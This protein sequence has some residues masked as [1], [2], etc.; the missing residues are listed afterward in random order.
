VL[1]LRSVESGQTLFLP[2][3]SGGNWPTNFFASVPVN[4][5]A[6]G[7]ALA[8][9]FVNGIPSTASVVN[10]D[11]I[12]VPT[13]ITLTGAKVLPNGSFQLVFTNR[14]GAIFSALSTT[15]LLLPLTQWTVL[16]SVTEGPAGQFQV[17]DPQAVGSPQHFYRVRSP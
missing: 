9:V 1:Q 8:T 16:G 4:S 12:P 13:A 17:I 10:I 5:L 6:L 7:Y 2:C 15:N 14:P 3:A 11:N